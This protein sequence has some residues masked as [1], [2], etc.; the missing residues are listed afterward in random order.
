VYNRDPRRLPQEHKFSNYCLGLNTLNTQYINITDAASLRVIGDITIKCWLKVSST[1]L[2]HFIVTKTVGSIAAPWDFYILAPTGTLT[3]FRGN[4]A[5]SKVVSGYNIPVGRWFRLGLTMNATTRVVSFYRDGILITS[6]IMPAGAVAD[7]GKDLKIGTRT[8]FAAY[9]T[10]LID[11][12]DVLNVCQT[13]EEMMNDALRGYARQEINSVLNLRLE[14]GGGLTV[15]DSSGNGNNGTL[16]P[17]LTPPTWTR[18]A[19][20]EPLTEASF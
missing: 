18:T 8:D 10:Y 16:T 17:A 6:P 3:F 20:Y 14:E 2:S 13:S 1:A 5:G 15:Y 4:G 7:G 12:I 19:K 9:A 11:E